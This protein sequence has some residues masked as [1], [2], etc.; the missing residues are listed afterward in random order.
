[1]DVCS[2]LVQKTVM[3]PVMVTGTLDQRAILSAGIVLFL[4][5]STKPCNSPDNTILIFVLEYESCSNVYLKVRIGPTS[6]HKWFTLLSFLSCCKSFNF[7]SYIRDI[8]MMCYVDIICRQ[9]S[10]MVCHGCI[11]LARDVR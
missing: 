2:N 6:I 3:R 4:F 9:H 10:C 5:V 7:Y 8:M 11:V 1:M